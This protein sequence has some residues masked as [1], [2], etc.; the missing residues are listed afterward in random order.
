[1]GKGES[2]TGFPGSEKGILI[3]FVLGFGKNS[4]DSMTPGGIRT[5]GVCGDGGFSFTAELME[6]I[7]LDTISEKGRVERNLMIGVIFES[8]APTTIKSISKDDVVISEDVSFVGLAK[9][10]SFLDRTWKKGGIFAG[11]M[12]RCN[13]CGVLSASFELTSVSELIGTFSIGEDFF[14][15][16]GINWVFNEGGHERKRVNAEIHRSDGGGRKRVANVTRGRSN[17]RIHF[18][19]EGATGLREMVGGKIGDDVRTRLAQDCS[20]IDKHLWE[21]RLRTGKE[22][23]RG[24]GAQ[25]LEVGGAG[26]SEIGDTS[27]DGLVNDFSGIQFFPIGERVSLTFEE[28]RMDRIGNVFAAEGVVVSNKMSGEFSTSEADEKHVVGEGKERTINVD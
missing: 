6:F 10:K 27:F 26:A 16:K 14:L 21:D 18:H 9:T 11:L 17:S 13:Q 7:V 20:L 2:L 23:G 19:V 8:F 24:V 15:G 25:K 4:D 3:D 5:G 28:S 1:M 22:M 12:F